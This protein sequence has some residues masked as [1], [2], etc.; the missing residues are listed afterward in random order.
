MICP[1]HGGPWGDDDT[2]YLCGF[3]GPDEIVSVTILL[4]RDDVDL[5]TDGL[6]RNDLTLLLT[7]EPYT[8]EETP[9]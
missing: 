4:H 2:C 7:E 3:H 1:K 9:R 8:P 5:V 6:N